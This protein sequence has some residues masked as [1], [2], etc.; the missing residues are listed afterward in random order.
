MVREPRS[1]LYFGAG[2]SNLRAFVSVFVSVLCLRPPLILCVCVCVSLFVC[3]LACLF[4]CLFVC[5][6][7]C[8]FVCLFVCV[9]VCVSVGV[10][11]GGEQ[12]SPE[13]CL[14]TNRTR[15]TP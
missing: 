13:I 2:M 3:L 1:L 14:P 6:L 7:V 12:N 10:L 5:L 4:A 9:C 15:F 11:G 8:L